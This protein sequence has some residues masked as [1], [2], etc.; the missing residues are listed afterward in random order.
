MIDQRI[1]GQTDDRSPAHL[2]RAGIAQLERTAQSLRDIVRPQ[3]LARITQGR[4]Y[5]DPAQGAETVAAGE[6]DLATIDRQIAELDSVL[7]NAQVVGDGPAPPMVQLGFLVTVRDTDGESRTLTVVSP[8]EADPSSSLISSDS[9]VGKALL[10]KSPGHAVT[11]DADDQ[12][13][14]LQIDKIDSASVS[15]TA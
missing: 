1:S 13:F 12:T 8:L 15:A 9:P 11:V 5:M 7:A 14:T 6:I 2:T 4:L 3:I 10:G